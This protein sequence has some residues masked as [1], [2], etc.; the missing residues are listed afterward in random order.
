M[1]VGGQR[2]ERRKW[3]HCFEGVNAVAF[4]VAISEYDQTLSDDF[5][6]NRMRESIKVFQQI[7]NSRWFVN[8]PMLLFLNKKDVF[9]EKMVYSPISQCFPEFNDDENRGSEPEYIEEQFR[10]ENKSDRQIYCHLTNAKDAANITFI[11]DVIFDVIM[12][13]NIKHLGMF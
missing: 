12:N 4:V 11:F 5:S 13:S 2:T 9:E 10:K 8:S 7:C 3:L 1:D 6:T